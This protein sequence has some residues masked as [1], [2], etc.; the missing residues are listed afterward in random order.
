MIKEEALGEKFLHR[1]KWLYLFTLLWA[2]LGYII[3]IILSRDLSI[4]DFGIFYGIISL[5][6]LLSAINDI[7]CT[8]SLNYILPQY[9]IKKQYSKVKYLLKF[10]F[11][12]Q[13]FSSVFIIAGL[14]FLADWIAI[15]HFKSAHASPILKVISL[16][17]LGSNLFQICVTIFTATQNTKLQKI[18]DFIRL[19]ATVL[20]V[21]GI[22]AFDWWT[23]LTYT[24]GWIGGLFIGTLFAGI[25]FYKDYYKPYLENIPTSTDT[26]IRKNFTKHAV[27]AF[28]T[29]NVNL[30][31]SQIDSQ[32]IIAFTNNEWS[33]FY[34]NYLSIISLPFLVLSPI[35]G[36]LFPVF[37]ELYA[38]KE[39]QKIRII[40][41]N[42]MLYLIILSLWITAFFFQWGEYMARILFG[43]HYAFSGK[44][45][46]ASIPFLI[47]N[48]LNQLNLQL[49][50]WTGHTKSRTISFLVVLPINII[51]N[52]ILIQKLW[53][54]G[55]ALAVGISW[56]P[57]YAMTLYA[58]KEYITFPK[59]KYIIINIFWVILCIATTHILTPFL[60]TNSWYALWFMTILYG[61]IFLLINYSLLINGFK[62]LKNSKK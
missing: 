6:T 28:I 48:V 2:P 33:A 11:K 26:S 62:T 30:L 51:L 38:R 9:I 5:I 14:F 10:V 41:Q 31:L 29:A 61:I 32:L 7:G 4:N 8:E 21:G 12:I 20:F 34:S 42:M 53:V 39:I 35:L 52:I 13:L 58:S 46:Q 25:Y 18:S 37:S 15:T 55:S 1:W 22:F 19:L 50:A 49:L 16:F 23:L 36:F 57:L 59:A 54:I 60:H 17:F 44:I 43:D 24:W 3:K 56:I 45:I 27:P 40:Y 47:L